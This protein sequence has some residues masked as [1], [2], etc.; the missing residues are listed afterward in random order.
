[1]A[2]VG[3][4]TVLLRAQILTGIAAFLP[5]LAGVLSHV[6]RANLDSRRPPQSRGTPEDPHSPGEP[7]QVPV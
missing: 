4:S 1:M 2:K 3:Q 5:G 6:L 7:A